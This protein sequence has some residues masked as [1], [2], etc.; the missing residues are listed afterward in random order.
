MTC[1]SVTVQTSHREANSSHRENPHPRRDR[2]HRIGI[3]G[4]TMLVI[5]PS[6]FG[7][8]PT[9]LL[10]RC[11]LELGVTYYVTVYLRGQTI[12]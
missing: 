3:E 8:H 11:G 9:Q 12:R 2:P 7:K 1:C 10:G 6:L 5:S 4:V